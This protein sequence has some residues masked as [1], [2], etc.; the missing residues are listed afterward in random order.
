[1]YTDVNHREMIIT[2]S[3]QSQ[4]K[5]DAQEMKTTNTHTCCPVLYCARFWLTAGTAWNMF[6]M[7]YLLAGS[8]IFHGMPPHPLS[9]KT[10]C[11]N[12][13]S[14]ITRHLFFWTQKPVTTLSSLRLHPQCYHLH[15]FTNYP[16]VKYVATVAVDQTT[17]CKSAWFI[18]KFQKHT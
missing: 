11:S 2:E 1:M 10:A 14:S 17:V 8:N 4:I 15:S 13:S 3:Q 18:P 7:R 16:A 5:I 9:L 6:T 12:M